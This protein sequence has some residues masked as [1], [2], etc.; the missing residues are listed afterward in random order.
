MWFYP[1]F[2]LDVKTSIVR[3]FLKLVFKHFQYSRKFYRIFNSSTLKVSY[4]SCKNFASFIKH[5]NMNIIANYKSAHSNRRNCYCRE[6]SW[7]KNCWKRNCYG[8]KVQVDVSQEYKT[9]RRASKNYSKTRFHSHRN[10][11]LY[12]EDMVKTSLARY[13]SV[14]KKELYLSFSYNLGNS[15]ESI[16][17]QVWSL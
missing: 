17:I 2:N 11:F 3:E 15:R 8:V 5:Y 6:V 10:Y 14:L 9:C 13:A 4:V 1:A 7:K 12:S 16:T